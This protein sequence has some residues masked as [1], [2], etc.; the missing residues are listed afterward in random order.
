MSDALVDRFWIAERLREISDL[1]RARDETYF[2]SRTYRRAAETLEA[3]L[4]A[5]VDRRFEA[6]TLEELP[7]IG[8]VI[9]EQIRAL[10]TEGRSDL[11]DELRR[12]LP[13]TLLE[14]HWVRG[15]SLAKAKR[16]RAA[17]G[18][19]SVDDLA[20]AC[21]DQ[22]VRTVKGFGARTEAALARAVEDYRRTP[23]H[24]RVLEAHAM[25]HAISL[26]LAL[27][28]AV[29]DVVPAGDLRRGLAT[30]GEI[31]FVCPTDDPERVIAHF[32]NYPLLARLEQIHRE[33]DDA[34]RARVVAARGR[35]STGVSVRIAA[36]V[37]ALLP[38][39]LFIETGPADHVNDV[40][41]RASITGGDT[42]AE[43]RAIYRHAGLPFVH[44][45]VRDDDSW[46]AR[47]GDLL[48]PEDV[49]GMV[50][51]HTTHSDGRE[52][53][54][55]MAA[56]AKALGFDYITITDHSP[57]AH[58]AGGVALDRLAAQWDEI[59]EAED[60][61]GIRVLRGTESDILADG[62]LDYPDSVLE[63][64][65]VVIAS[66]HNRYRMP[67][68]AMTERIVRCMELPVF[69]IWGHPL[70]Q[71]VLRR[72]PIGCD[73]DRILD[74][75]A[76][77]PAAIEINGDPY[78][79]DLPAEWARRARA[80][81]IRFVVSADAHSTRG[82]RNMEHAV[83]LARRSGLGASD[84]LNTLGAHDFV[85]AVR[86]VAVRRPSGPCN[87]DRV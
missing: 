8:P 61:L 20:R 52:T 2:P 56:H 29:L 77:S 67:P 84:V 62:A 59:A 48:R 73:V 74:V 7:F 39:T 42:V 41:A 36:C 53:V 69:K 87:E 83:R 35:L 76:R 12:E 70:G 38:T 13:R 11:L 1:V 4:P 80:L 30:T 5:E 63:K 50:H 40:L 86:P 57:T 15:M 68:D 27:E 16:L 78:R 51:C 64:L 81:G 49:R 24:V 79:L 75:V 54:W 37:P 58:Y 19:E 46:D 32:V 18:V 6:G 43:E 28:R 85:R 71:L 65:D 34:G 22:R 9:A 60:R 17:I 47:R 3:T 55:E 82:M 10:A 23:E 66:I 14:L 44:A 31:A 45:E 26:H 72:P 33:L 25:L 21:A